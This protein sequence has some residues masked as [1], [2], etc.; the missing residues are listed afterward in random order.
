ME[1]DQSENKIILAYQNPEIL[2]LILDDYQMKI[3]LI[4]T[5]IPNYIDA[6]MVWENDNLFLL[7]LMAKDESYYSFLSFLWDGEKFINNRNITFKK[8]VNISDETIYK[9]R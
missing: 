4:E 6:L 2:S 7:A 5:S 3:D 8:E 9:C 1:W